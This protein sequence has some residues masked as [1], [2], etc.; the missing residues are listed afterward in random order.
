M[1]CMTREGMGCLL[2][3]W[4]TNVWPMKSKYAGLWPQVMLGCRC[5]SIQEVLIR[6]E[7]SEDVAALLLEAVIRQ[8]WKVRQEC[9]FRVWESAW[10]I[11]ASQYLK[12]DQDT[13][14]KK[15]TDDM[16]LYNP[17]HAFLFSW[18]F[19][20]HGASTL[21][22]HKPLNKSYAPP[23][24]AP[25]PHD[26][27]FAS[28]LHL[29]PKH[30]YYRVYRLLRISVFGTA[31]HTISCCHGRSSAVTSHH[32]LQPFVKH[33]PGS[34]FWVSMMLLLL[35]FC[36]IIMRERLKW[37]KRRRCGCCGAICLLKSS[38]KTWKLDSENATFSYLNKEF[39]CGS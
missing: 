3:R 2:T 10:K 5:C 20:R 34:D 22:K 7:Y 25:K 38:E 9:G 35:F 32:W 23:V 26:H 11:P 6:A 16:Q 28:L 14:E 12:S 1:C 18:M 27:F 8:R 31:V 37:K 39:C 21:M 24:Y 29:Q 17:F 36:Y 19:H 13:V 33:N 15:P 30:K 4:C